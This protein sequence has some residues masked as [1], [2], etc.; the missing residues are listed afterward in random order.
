MHNLC[1]VLKAGN[2]DF[3]K[4]VKTT[5]YLKDM[6][7]F[8]KVNEVYGSYFGDNPPARATI[9]VSRLPKD[10]LVEIDMIAHA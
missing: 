4:I 10:V 7:D 8:Q 9:E 5:I 2:T 1:E 3:T 6:N